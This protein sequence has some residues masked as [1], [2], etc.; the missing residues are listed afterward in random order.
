MMDFA[1][2]TTQGA[3][4]RDLQDD[5]G[6]LVERAFAA[7]GQIGAY[8]IEVVRIFDDGAAH[9]QVAFLRDE[10]TPSTNLDARIREFGVAL[11]RDDEAGSQ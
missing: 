4:L 3:V 2:V 1:D 6:S 10:G 11:V 5:P 9:A 7:V 8:D